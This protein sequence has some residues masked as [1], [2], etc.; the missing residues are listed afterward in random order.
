MINEIKRIIDGYLNNL[1]LPAV[2]I[3]TYTGSSITINDKLNIPISLVSGDLKKMM[4][5]GNKVRLF[6]STGWEE[7]YILEIIGKLP[8]YKEDVK[9]EA[10]K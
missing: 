9:Q 6:A 2:L 7:F 10:L 3:G 1:K 4:A 8:L 5:A